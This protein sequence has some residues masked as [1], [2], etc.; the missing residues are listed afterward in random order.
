MI[1]FKKLQ[2]AN[3][4]S[5]E[6]M[7]YTADVYWEGRPLGHIRN[8]GNGGFSLFHMTEKAEKADYQ[9][10]LAFAKTQKQD[11]GEGYGM[12]PFDH[13]ED[14]IDHVAGEEGDRQSAGRWLVRTMKTKIVLLAD[15][16]IYTCKA[17]WEG[18]TARIEQQLKARHPG[19][20]ILN[21]LPKEEAIAKYLSAA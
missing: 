15:G 19:A 14:Y 17:K 3:S 20:V 10:A 6:T 2:I 12:V 11:L 16:K 4:L 5:E 9:A 18:D 7:A 13:L 8:D 1:T 21:P